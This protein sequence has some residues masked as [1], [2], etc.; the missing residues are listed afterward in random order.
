MLTTRTGSFPIGF[1]RGGSDWQKDL[2]SL[3]CWALS[4]ELSV[5]DV[6][7]DA[8]VVG[9]K[10][11]AAGMCIGSADLADLRNLLSADKAKRTQAIT[12]NADYIKA[13]TDA[14]ARNFFAVMIPDKA[15][16]PRRDNFKIMVDSLS[17]LAP[18]LERHQGRIVIEGWPGPGALCC[19]PETLRATFKEVGSRSIGI[20]YDPSHLIRMGID[21]IRF[22]EEFG[23]RVYHAHGKDAEILTENLYEYGSEQPA[24]FSEPFFCG[25]WHWRYT[26]PGHGQMRWTQAFQILKNKHYAGAISVELEDANFNGGT[27]NE[28]QGILAGAR[29]LQLC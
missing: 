6:W 14:G 24:A 29:F 27:A 2:D 22:L 8:D 15:D 9:P 28:Q 4:N 3:I 21:P 13:A 1:R 20:N 11:A 25:A 7:A 17:A 18:V 23:D 12:K 5:I 19:T 10:I 26:I 16:L